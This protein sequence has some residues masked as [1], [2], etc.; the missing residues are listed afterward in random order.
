MLLAVAGPAALVMFW[1]FDVTNHELMLRTVVGID[2]AALALAS[3]VA[4][5]LFTDN[6][7]IERSSRCYGRGS[8]TSSCS[9]TWTYARVWKYGTR[10][11]CRIIARSKHCLC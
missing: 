4:A 2:S 8:T 6:G 10:C 3:G 5:A 11:R 7:S 9:S 1:S